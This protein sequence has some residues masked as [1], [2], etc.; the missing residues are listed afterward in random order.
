[1]RIVHEGEGRPS[2]EAP[3]GRRDRDHRGNG[4]SRRC[5]EGDEFVPNLAVL[6]P[7]MAVE[8][9][10][11]IIRSRE[12]CEDTEMEP[13]PVQGQVWAVGRGRERPRFSFS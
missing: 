11:C 2:A 9:P 13:E 1:M 3:V 12:S 10:E 8:I 6:S 4:P 7:R 5:A